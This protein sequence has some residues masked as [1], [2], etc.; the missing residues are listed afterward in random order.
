M[1][2]PLRHQWILVET[3]VYRPFTPF[4]PLRIVEFAFLA[5][6][7]VLPEVQCHIQ[8]MIALPENHAVQPPTLN[9]KGY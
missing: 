2:T 5:A 3:L 8:L 1:I 7:S 6:I 9:Q 4:P